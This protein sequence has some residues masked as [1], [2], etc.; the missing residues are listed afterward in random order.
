MTGVDVTGA[1]SSECSV[2]S[3][4]KDVNLNG[5]V[6]NT[7]GDFDV[8]IEF[9]TSGMLGD[10]IQSTSFI[11]SDPDQALTLDMLNLAD[12]GLRFTSVGEMDGSRTDSAKIGGGSSGVAQN[13]VLSAPENGSSSVNL[14][15]ND[16]SS[17]NAVSSVSLNGTSYAVGTTRPNMISIRLRRL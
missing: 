15:L 10:D 8:G 6:T 3:V 1:V 5:E 13:D 11:L 12:F 9:G 2:D 17:G 14:L 16:Q 7:L 4:R